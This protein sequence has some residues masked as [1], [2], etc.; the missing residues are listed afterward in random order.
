VKNLPP[1]P[2]LRSGLAATRH[3]YGDGL[4]AAKAQGQ[5]KP[6]PERSEGANCLERIKKLTI[7]TNKPSRI[8]TQI[9]TSPIGFP[10]RFKFYV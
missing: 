5:G 7:N 9:G 3:P 6:R 2:S 8:L 1:V 4:H 10:K